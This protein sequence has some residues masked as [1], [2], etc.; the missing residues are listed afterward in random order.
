MKV[1]PYNGEVRFSEKDFETLELDA[2]ATPGLLLAQRTVSLTA[3]SGFKR[4]L[5][6]G[7]DA[8]ISSPAGF[9]KSRKKRGQTFGGLASCH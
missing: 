3:E 1:R 2:F 8:L 7:H 9:T 4:F 6:L 5:L